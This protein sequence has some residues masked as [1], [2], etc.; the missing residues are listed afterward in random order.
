MMSTSQAQNLNYL[1]TKVSHGIMVA[2]QMT[3]K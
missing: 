3:L 1:G 2:N